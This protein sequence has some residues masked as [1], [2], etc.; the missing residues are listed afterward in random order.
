MNCKV[1]GGPLTGI[2]NVCPNCG[3]PVEKEIPVVDSTVPTMVSNPA[4]PE[5]PVMPVQP[6][7]PAAPVVPEVQAVPV[8]PEVPAQPVV[9]EV[10][11]QPVVPEV[12]A[13]PVV[14]EIPVQPEAQ[15]VQP[16]T[17]TPAIQS[18]PEM[19]A[20]PVVQPEVAP[21]QPVMNNGIPVMNSVQPVAPMTQPV[22]GGAAQP[23]TEKPKQNKTVLLI[24]ILIGVVA[25]AAVSLFAL[26]VFDSGDDDDSGNS[27]GNSGSGDV[28]DVV[29]NTQSYAGYT[30]TIPE[31]YE[32]KVDAKAGLGIY[33]QTMAFTV[34]VDYTNSY[35]TYKTEFQKKYPDQ[36]EKMVE[37]INGREY[38]ALIL[39]QDGKYMTYYMSKADN[40]ATFIGGVAN[41]SYTAPTKVEFEVLTT[42][43]DSAKSSSTFA[44]GDD[45]DAGKN[46]IVGYEFN[47][48]D[49]KFE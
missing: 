47:P 45:E 38:V 39:T 10:Q 25:I 33:N 41:S 23:G 21:Q 6:E 42:I 13:A 8:A 46:G 16:E 2:E 37:T 5:A 34:A 40:G 24:I 20:A 29:E 3:N 49:W 4:V 17:V 32:T 35:E 19:P 7:M 36:A 28:V 31:G 26:G 9:P 27:G 22:A 14:P 44:P 1:C 48:S 11:V 12:P 30:F 18:M 43:L 15:V